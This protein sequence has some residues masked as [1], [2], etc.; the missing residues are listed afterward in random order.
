[1]SDTVWRWAQGSFAQLK[2]ELFEISTEQS[3]SEIIID[4]ASPGLHRIKI[5]LDGRNR[6]SPGLDITQDGKPNLHPDLISGDPQQVET[7]SQHFDAIHNDVV[8]GWIDPN[9]LESVRSTDEIATLIRG[10]A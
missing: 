1:M 7:S 3:E 9:D 6:A 10:L 2:T 5:W 4:Q 8:S